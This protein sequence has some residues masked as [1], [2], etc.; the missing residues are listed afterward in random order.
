MSYKFEEGKGVLIEA[1]VDRIK[2]SMT[3]EQAEFCAEFAKQLYGTVAMEDLSAWELDDLYGAVANFWSLLSERKPH[4]T[5]IRIYNPDFE[6]HGW[7][8]THTVIEV[9]CDDMPFLVDSIRLVIHR[10]GLASHLSIH[11]G[12]IRVKRAPNNHISAILPRDSAGE[13]DGVINEAPI[14][15]EIDRQT[16]PKV[17]QE[18]HDRCLHVLEDNRVVFEDWEKMRSEVREAVVEIDKVSSVLDAGEVTETKAFL[19]WIEDHHFT[20]LGIR[21]YELVQKGSETLLQ[22]IPETGLGLLR[23]SVTKSMTR[24][25]SAMAPEAREFTL[26]PRILVMSKTNTLASVHRDAY[27]DYIGIK[28][29]DAQGNVIGER[30]IIGLYTSAAYHTNP[31]QIPFL[32][33]KVAVIMENSQLKP[34]SHAAKVL[35]NILETLPRDDLIQGTEEELLEI[36]MGIFYMQDRK[37]IRLFAR[38]DVYRRFVSCLVYVPKERVNTELRLAM[39]RIL[40]TSF[41]AVETNYTT[42][43]TESVLARIHFI[44]KIDPENCPDYDF[45]EIEM[46]LIEAG[47]SWTDDLQYNLYEA[48]GEEQANSL[49]ARYRGSFP[50]AYCENFTARTAV[51]DIKHIEML[52]PENPLGINFYR[53]LDESENNFRLKVYHHDATIPLSDV[54]PILENLGLR[55]ITERPYALKF[56]DGK[57]TWVNDFAIQY[58]KDGGVIELDDIKELFQNA[59]AKVWFSNAENDGFNQLVLAAGLDWRE[60]AI[61]RTYAKYFKQMGFTFSQEY[62]ERALNNNVNIAK[63]LVQ[64][65]EIRC[66]PAEENALRDHRFTELS[67]EIL[68]DLDSVSNLDEDKIIRQYIHAIAATLRTNFY[69]VDKQGKP[70]DY[71]SIK[72]NSK[73]IPGLPKP[74]PMFE[75][76]VYSPRLE[77]VHLRCGKVARGGLRWS[78][79]RE[80]F[81]TEILGLMKAQQVKNSVIV[82][83]GAK[84]GFVPKNLPVNGS[85][86]DI[87]SEGIACYQIFIRGLLDI[88]DNYVDNS[89]VKPDHV[90]CHDEDDPYL[91]VAADKGTATFSDLA[92]AISLEYGFWLGDAF[93]SGGSVGY[94]HKKMGITAKG[95]WESVKRHFYELDI[96]IQNND[97]TVVGIGDMA[98][99]VFGN[100]M[101]LS[102]HIKLVGAFNHI[103][104]F[105][106]PDPNAE[107]SF[108]ERERLFNLPRSNWTDYDKKLI[109]KG[110]GV[111]NRNAKSIP[112]SKEMQ[113]VFG[114][115]QA[116]IEPNDLIKTILKAKVD[117]LW[118]GGIGT[119]VKA[120]SES[121]LNV[122]DR[123]NDA[124][125]VNAKQLRCKV[126]GEGGNLGLTQLARMEYSLGG[127]L[128][129]TDF[130]DNSGG[131]NCSDKEVNI[132]ILLNGIVAVGDLTPKQRNELLSEMTDDV[133]KLVLRDNFLQT[134]AISLSASQAMQAL[135]LQ[136]RYIKELE[137]TGKIDRNLEFLPDDKALQERKLMGQGLGRPGIAVLMCYSKSILKEQILASG[138]PEENYMEQ[139]LINSFPKQL[140]ERFSKQ[141]QDHPLKREIIA[142][143]LS[144]IIVNEM[145]FTYVY[146]LQDETGAPVSA[147]VRAYMITRTVLNLESIWKQ[148]EDLGTQINAKRQI[149]MMMF[150]VR[151]SRRITRWFL[152]TQ[153]KTMDITEVVKLY[154]Q[155]MNELKMSIPSILNEERRARYEEHHQELIK[156]GIPAGLAHELTVARGLFS[157]T[158][159]IEIASKR[160]M[161]VSEVAEVYFGIGEFL[162]LA[163]IRKQI[164]MH[165]T[166]NHWESLSREALRDDLDWQQRQLTDGLLNYDGASSDLQERLTSWG[167][168]HTALIERWHF[169]LSDLKASSVLNYTMFFVAIRELLDLTQTTLQ[170]YSE[171]EIA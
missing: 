14:F 87:M 166:D 129:Y 16:D 165:P 170:T 45:K 77:G 63:K 155:G 94:D 36:A 27:T 9:V 139:F 25:I 59:F 75:I 69:Q 82:P 49:F 5:K 1:I 4:E 133:A 66:N 47:R 140:Q 65:F 13:E 42:L 106:D 48:Y 157:A 149:E 103:H 119:Y 23:E 88:T 31:T 167:D 22:A 32:R 19:Q 107:L 100:G 168:A 163:W 126:I 115:K 79:R 121:N 76:F 86:E 108:K 46:K 80:D 159:I 12:G 154:S 2:N 6:R 38:M 56:D 98:G 148:I 151:L 137:R 134:R 33:R 89:V 101:L 113:E 114:I 28:R 37:R 39:K 96:D 50:A 84:G 146:R 58:N 130:I 53:A 74:Y 132:K 67:E 83:S 20:F 71:I 141:M 17:L 112:V 57:V 136:G 55:A 8:T 72:L 61:L 120:S 11:M 145:G 54:L 99:D 143:K 93:A 85:R 15:L 171:V 97:F 111:F 124:T 102:K 110:G 95:A 51:Y 123:A 147:I 62:M 30:R 70:K 78:D 44:I 150:Y 91:V 18:L 153:R 60:V 105:V 160:N 156:E 152:R 125:R 29:F 158:D 131:V 109:S 122:G 116:E 169:I 40:D 142:T 7:Q 24:S 3:G 138:V 135:V 21:D 73:T 162:D 161:K 81:R 68:V 144:N 128:V 41:N 164:I 92:N 90:V 52:N 118:S 10:M 34:R 127:G 64:L 43:F 26:S 35:L 104:I 117:L